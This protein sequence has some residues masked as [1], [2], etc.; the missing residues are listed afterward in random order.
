[1]KAGI[2]AEGVEVD[3]P[4]VFR[5]S[6]VRSP[7][8]GKQS[9]VHTSREGISGVQ[10]HRT[11]TLLFRS[12]PVPLVRLEDEREN[13]MRPR[14][15]LVYGKCFECSFLGHRYNLVGGLEEEGAQELNSGDTGMGLA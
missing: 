1:M 2:S 6:V 7:E 8:A 10:R 15:R 13:R 11:T 12:D 4:L 5:D 9:H 3:G 14:N